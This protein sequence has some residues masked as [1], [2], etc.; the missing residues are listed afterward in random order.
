MK[1]PNQQKLIDLEVSAS[2]TATEVLIID[3]QFRLV[4]RGVGSVTTQLQPGIYKVQA[5][6][7]EQVQEDHIILRKGSKPVKKQFDPVEFSSASLLDNTTKT[8]EFQTNAAEDESKQVH[9]KHGTGSYI[10]VF[11]REWT[12]R[13]QPSGIPRPQQH[14]AKGLVLCD[15][16]GNELV[17]LEKES[18]S[19]L[20]S[21]H[22]WEAWAA[23]NIRVNPG[24]Y[25]L[26]LRL[27]DGVLSVEEKESL[28]LEQTIV[29]ASGWQTQVFLLQRDYGA[30]S[31]ARAADLT[32][33]SILLAHAEPDLTGFNKANQDMRLMETARIGL[34]NRRRILS[35]E[36]TQLFDGKIENPMLGIYG[37]HLLLLDQE[38]D[39]QRFTRI[40]YKLRSLLREPH[41]DVEAL[42]LR[43]EGG[44]SY[45]FELPPMLRR[46]WSFILDATVAHP[47]LVPSSSVSA[48]IAT[49]IWGEDPWLLWL[50]SP[51]KDGSLPLSQD[52]GGAY[53][54]IL[55]AQLP[56]YGTKSEDFARGLRGL[57]IFAD[58]G[59]AIDDTMEMAVEPGEDN[60]WEAG[61]DS[62]DL[63]MS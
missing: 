58:G 40:V 27:P 28:N 43:T 31:K 10:F 24:I 2:D 4:E 63:S 7:G 15:A 53:Q 11:A 18:N 49:S 60:A 46:S 55:Q 25:R 51:A 54:A 37:A 14:P 16:K 23:C 22:D 50:Y 41:P 38:P 59:P 12:G 1:T 42:A 47:E 35:Q 3:G 45:V 6:I 39:M 21:S 48:R 36:I 57:P 20:A 17:D 13:D 29:A 26:R 30:S 34:T 33:A 61:Q 52:P 5:R 32:G 9:A 62:K 44:S 56:N 19:S 8:H